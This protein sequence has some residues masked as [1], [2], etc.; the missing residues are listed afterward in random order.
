MRPYVN[1][2]FEI[3]NLAHW[4]AHKFIVGQ[5]VDLASTVLRPAAAGEYEILRLMPASDS[6]PQNPCYRIKNIDEKHERVVPES[7]LTLAR[8]AGAAFS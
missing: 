7:D 6:D 1:D 3:A 5:A 2:D 8:P 4:M